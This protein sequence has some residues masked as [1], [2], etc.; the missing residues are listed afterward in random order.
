M[1]KWKKFLFFLTIISYKLAYADGLL[2]LS[3]KNTTIISGAGS[4]K[5][6]PIASQ[7]INMKV[8]AYF[9][10]VA[11]IVTAVLTL[12]FNS[13]NSLKLFA[14]LFAVLGIVALAYLSL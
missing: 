2:G 8:V 4:S 6:D 1:K 14:K 10:S 11:M 9:L 7:V 3:S 13:E 5:L 12:Y